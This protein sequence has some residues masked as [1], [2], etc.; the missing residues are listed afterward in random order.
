MF[1]N[2]MGIFGISQCHE[3]RESE[4]NSVYRCLLGHEV[5]SEVKNKPNMITESNG[6][7][8]FNVGR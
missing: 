7:A 3:L 5:S 8:R 6:S 2:A 1:A 4:I